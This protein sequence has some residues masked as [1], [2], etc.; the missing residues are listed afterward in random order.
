M[1][2]KLQ[3]LLFEDEELEDE[4]L[5]EDDEEAEEEEVVVKKEKPARRRRGRRHEEE[6]TEEEVV[7]EPPVQ[8]PVYQAKPEPA[9]AAKPV[10]KR[11]EVTQAISVPKAEQPAPQ[12]A[13]A[14][15]KPNAGYNNAAFQKPAAPVQ[16]AT[17]RPIYENRPAKEAA[18]VFKTPE[19]QPASSFG[20]SAD[21]TAGAAVRTQP[22]RPEPQ[23][24]Q[25]VKRPGA[26]YEFRPV[27][28]P[29]FGVDE[30]DINAMAYIA[31]PEP[32]DEPDPTHHATQ[33]L[34]PIYGVNEGTPEENNPVINEVPPI[35]SFDGSAYQPQPQ[36][37]ENTFPEFSLDDILS[38]RDEEFT[39][40]NVFNNN[41]E[42][43]TPDI[44]ETA[45]I[46]SNQYSPYDQQT[47][48]F[49]RKR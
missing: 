43:R 32:V 46:D 11:V 16:H 21:D 33:L 44:D 34:S 26:V 9:P 23:P 1:L 17:P 22:R 12:E 19:P 10:L 27:I 4:E 18:P 42:Y 35:P 6:E 45:V 37:D 25:T 15:R 40:Q 7:E 36:P 30:K 47:L 13:P 39:R 29:M 2:K 3:N 20:I 28:S 14:V 31:K 48:D 8:K 5:E 24:T 41:Q 38:A 49:D